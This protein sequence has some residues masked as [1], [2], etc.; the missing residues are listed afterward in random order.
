MRQMESR[1]FKLAG[2]YIHY[3]IIKH[4]RGQKIKKLDFLSFFETFF[5][6][7]SYSM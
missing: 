2:N 5:S 7:H 1:I 4:I 6:F 3:S